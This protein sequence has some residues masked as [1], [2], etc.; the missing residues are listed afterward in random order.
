MIPSNSH[1]YRG[2]NNNKKK[3]PKTSHPCFRFNQSTKSRKYTTKRSDPS[4]R[5]ESSIIIERDNNCKLIPNINMAKFLTC[6]IQ[7]FQLTVQEVV[8][9]ASDSI[10]VVQLAGSPHQTLRSLVW[11]DSC[12]HGFHKHLQYVQLP[13]L[14]DSSAPWQTKFT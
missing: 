14:A 5:A 12:F 4:Y 11:A 7:C 6:P 2:H 10:L 13:L 8:I 3:T 9:V 1:S